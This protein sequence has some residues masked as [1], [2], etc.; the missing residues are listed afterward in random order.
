MLEIKVS[1]DQNPCFASRKC[2]HS[3]IAPSVIWQP[4]AQGP[5]LIVSMTTWKKESENNKRFVTRSWLA[6]AAAQGRVDVSAQRHEYVITPTCEERH[7][8]LPLLVTDS[9]KSAEVTRRAEGHRRG[10]PHG[11]PVC[12]LVSRDV[13]PLQQLTLVC[14]LMACPASPLKNV[15]GPPAW[16]RS[17]VII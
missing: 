14:L 6:P 16:N 5:L 11:A 9:T 3:R 4:K 8:L 2:L 15:A 7:F 12:P 17:S 1:I 10:G 13:E